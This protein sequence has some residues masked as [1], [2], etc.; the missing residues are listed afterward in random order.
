MRQYIGAGE[1]TY[2]SSKAKRAFEVNPFLLS[3]NKC[4]P[5]LST[6]VTRTEGRRGGASSQSFEKG[7]QSEA[8]SLTLYIP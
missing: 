8:F 2:V 3:S 1:F 6:Y 7:R 4:R 5:H